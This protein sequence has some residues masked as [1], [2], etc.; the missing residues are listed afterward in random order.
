MVSPKTFLTSD[1]HFYHKNILEFL[2]RVYYTLVKEEAWEFVKDS[3]F[4]VVNFKVLKN[5]SFRRTRELMP[6]VF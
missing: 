6:D 1:L 5:V 3:N 2:N 4:P